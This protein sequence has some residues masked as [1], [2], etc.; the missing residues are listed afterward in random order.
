MKKVK[1]VFLALLGLTITTF[2]AE[3]RTI[4]IYCPKQKIRTEITTPLPSGWW[5]TPQVGSLLETEVKNLAGKPTIF[6]KYWAYGTKV[7]IMK[8]APRGYICHAVNKH[9]QCNSIRPHPIFTLNGTWYGRA[10]THGITKLKIY[11]VGSQV[12]VDA[13][14]KCHPNDCNWG[15][16]NAHVINPNKIE[17]FWDQGFVRRRMIIKKVGLNRIKV[18]TRSHYVDGSGRADKITV[19]FMHK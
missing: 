7:S 6:C 4:N 5:Q 3:A 10:D 17:V 14:G 1:M 11:K 2:Y 16:R 12:K 18:R 13:W 19:E 8:R 15:V 9:V